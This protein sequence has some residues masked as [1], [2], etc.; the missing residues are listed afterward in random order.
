MKCG[1]AMLGP[2]GPKGVPPGWAQFQGG[3]GKG[4]KKTLRRERYLVLSPK[5]WV[6]VSQVKQGKKLRALLAERTAEAKAWRNELAGRLEPAAALDGAGRRGRT[7]TG[8]PESPALAYGCSPPDSEGRR[9]RS[10]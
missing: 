1:W 8:R 5:S 10:A 4:Q 7:E 6:S 3:G 2:E 9:W